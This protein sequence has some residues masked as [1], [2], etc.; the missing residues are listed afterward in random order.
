MI[1]VNVSTEKNAGI[2][3]TESN[4]TKTFIGPNHEGDFWLVQTRRKEKPIHFHVFD[5]S[6]SMPFAIFLK[7]LLL[8]KARVPKITY[9]SSPGVPTNDPAVRGVLRIAEQSFPTQ[10]SAELHLPPIKVRVKTDGETKFLEF[11]QGRGEVFHFSLEL[12]QKLVQYIPYV[13]TRG[14]I[15]FRRAT[16]AMIKSI[17]SKKFNSTMEVSPL[18]QPKIVEYKSPRWATIHHKKRKPRR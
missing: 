16:R 11:A 3:F 1:E 10:F 13:S 15:P 17:R 12:A 6:G 8:N 7:F 4:G 18:V 5:D 14:V 2:T 9:E